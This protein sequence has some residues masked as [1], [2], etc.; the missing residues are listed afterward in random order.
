MLAFVG[1]VVPEF[2]RIP[3]PDACYGAKTVVDAHNACVGNPPFPFLINTGD[4]FAG[5]DDQTGPLFQVYAFCGFVEMLTTFAKSCNV[6]N[7]PGLT[8]E[9]AGDYALGTQFLPSDPVKVKEMKLKELKNGRLAMLA[10]GGAIT[11]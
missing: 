1:L 8:L 3:G 9:N 2:V 6:S 5:N 10:F 4:F 11:Q 7:K